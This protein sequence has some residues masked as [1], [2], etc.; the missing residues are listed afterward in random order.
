MDVGR[1]FS[2]CLDY[3]GMPNVER[4][5]AIQIDRIMFGV[6]IDDALSSDLD[7]IKADSPFT[8]ACSVGNLPGMRVGWGKNWRW[9]HVRLTSGCF[10]REWVSVFG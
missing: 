9:G 3:K 5:H 1:R 8:L 6:K 2:A 4:T 7:A 10:A